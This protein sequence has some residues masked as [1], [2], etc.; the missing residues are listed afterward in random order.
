IISSSP[1]SPSRDRRP[2]TSSRS[3]V[4]SSDAPSL[5]WHVRSYDLP[6][7]GY[8]GRHRPENRSASHQK[9]HIHPFPRMSTSSFLSVLTEPLSIHSSEPRLRKSGDTPLF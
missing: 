5:P 6:V 4:C 1:A 7:T 9:A 8:R 3:V 2:T